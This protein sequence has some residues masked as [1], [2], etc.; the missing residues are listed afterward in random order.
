[1]QTFGLQHQCTATATANS[2][3]LVSRLKAKLKL[4][5]R[6]E[7]ESAGAKT[8]DDELNAD[9]NWSVEHVVESL[10]SI[11]FSSSIRPSLLVIHLVPTHAPE[12][13]NAQHGSL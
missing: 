7:D 1:V 9:G 8:V 5:A 10:P 4:R 11:S 2:N 6:L 13:A 12:R 3:C